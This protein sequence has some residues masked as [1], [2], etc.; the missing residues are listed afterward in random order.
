M[1]FERKRKQ[2]QSP[3]VPEDREV[4]PH[5]LL[6]AGNATLYQPLNKPCPEGVS[7]KRVKSHE[8][9]VGSMTRKKNDTPASIS[10][11]E[12]NSHT[13]IFLAPTLDLFY[14]MVEVADK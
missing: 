4:V 6:K 1:T 9:A 11:E 2:S 8:K 5:V 14:I 3:R 7:K 10:D 13:D 12:T